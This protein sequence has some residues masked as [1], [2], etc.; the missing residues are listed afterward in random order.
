MMMMMKMVMVMEVKMTK[1]A[2]ET[3]LEKLSLFRQI[4]SI[5]IDNSFQPRH[6]HIRHQPP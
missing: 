4:Q 3:S 6:M 5:K 2:M 1:A